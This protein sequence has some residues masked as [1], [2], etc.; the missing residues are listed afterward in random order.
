MTRLLVES[1]SFFVTPFSRFRAQPSA[2]LAVSTIH[3]RLSCYDANWRKHAESYSNTDALPTRFMIEQMLKRFLN[4][5]P[6]A[7]EILRAPRYLNPALPPRTPSH[8]T[9]MS[10]PES[11]TSV[12]FFKNHMSDFITNCSFHGFQCLHSWGDI[13]HVGGFL[14]CQTSP[15][16]CWMV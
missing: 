14:L 13:G 11:S 12:Q 2:T 4:L 15:A 1:S 6:R 9:H 7:L 3:S 5:G 16:V 10:W 8:L